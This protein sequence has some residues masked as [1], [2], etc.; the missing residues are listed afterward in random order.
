MVRVVDMVVSTWRRRHDV[1]VAVVDVYSGRAFRWAE[2]VCAVLRRA[3]VPF[4][5]VLRGGGLPSFAQRQ[6]DR[7][8]RLFSAAAAIVTLSDYLAER[9]K[10]HGEAFHMLPNPIDVDAYP[11]R[12]RR[13]VAPRLVWLRSFHATYHPE[14]APRVLAR[15]RSV[16]PEASLVMVGPDRGDGTLQRTRWLAERLG[17]ADAVEFVGPIP[18]ERVGEQLARGDVFLNTPR[19]DNVPISVLE[20][21]ACGMC[22]VSTD[23]GGIP[24][25]V[26]DGRDALLVPAGDHERMADAVLR[27][28][29]D[30]DLAAH[31]SQ[32]ARQVAEAHDWGAVL[33]RWE[34]LL[35]D[36][37][38]G[39][40]R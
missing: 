17:V 4:A 7:V 11:F 8:R 2:A 12:A 14:M 40:R 13:E 18:K 3:G 24:F 5:L 35:A 16:Y 31:L 28:C 23:V 22:V 29:G 21:M 10:G 34:E 6:P 38:R 36:L 26:Q 37:A 20:A 19:I 39:R 32:G 25:L 15:V 33:P 30:L 9:M 27:V 1:D